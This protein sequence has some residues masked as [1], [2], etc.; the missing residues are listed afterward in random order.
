MPDFLLGNR[1]QNIP[2]D[3]TDMEEDRRFNAKTLP[4][5]LGRSR[6]GQVATVCLVTAFFITFLVLWV[7]PLTFGPVYLLGVTGLG[8]WLLLLPALRLDQEN[9]RRLAMDLFNHASYYPLS[10]L[11]VTLVRIWLA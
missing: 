1:R 10:L 2:N 5:R 6:A 7:S 9:D 8:V 4:I 3:W 11:G